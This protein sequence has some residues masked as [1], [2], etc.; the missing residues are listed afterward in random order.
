MTSVYLSDLSHAHKEIIKRERWNAPTEV[1]MSRERWREMPLEKVQTLSKQADKS[2]RD[3]AEEES[4][5]EA[6]SPDRAGTTS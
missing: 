2:R 6:M 3:H 4:V 1:K 5:G